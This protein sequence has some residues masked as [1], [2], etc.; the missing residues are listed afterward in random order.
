MKEE[1]RKNAI[2]GKNKYQIISAFL[3]CFAISVCVLAFWPKPNTTTY[4]LETLD[5]EKYAY[6]HAVESHIPAYNYQVITVCIDGKVLNLA[7]KVDIRYT[8]N[9]CELIW[10]NSEI[11]YDDR[12]IL[13]IPQEAVEILPTVILK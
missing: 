7:G 1:N 9:R 5:G 10:T 4:S 6:Y 12:L 8:K 3:V 13:L 11:E 2:K